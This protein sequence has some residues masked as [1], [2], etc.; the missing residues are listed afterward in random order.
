MNIN[1]PSQIRECTSCQ[2]CGAVCPTSAISIALNQDG[3]YRPVI[4]EVKCIDCS[5]C[6][7]S[8]YKFDQ[9]VRMTDSLESHT[10]L[11]A[12]VKDKEILNS[13]TSGGI[14]DILAKELTR[15][16]YLCIGVKYN[17]Q[18]N[19]AEGSIAS[20]EIETDGF[21][22]SKYIQSLS[23]DAFKTLAKENRK[24]KFAVFGLPCHIYALD[25]FLKSINNREPHILIDLFCH[26]CPSLLIWKKYLKDEVKINSDEEVTYV[27]FRSKERGW[28]EY[29]LKVELKS[30]DSHRTYISP[31]INDPFFGLFFSELVL[32]NSC[33]DCIVRRTLEYSEIRLGDFWGNKFL[34]NTTGVSAI[35]LSSQR[36]KEL[37]N[38]IDLHIN[39]EKQDWQSLLPYQSY[40]KVYH[41]DESLRSRLFDLLRDEEIPIKKVFGEYLH[42][43]PL[44][45]RIKYNLKNIFKLLPP[46]SIKTFKLI[47]RK[48]ANSK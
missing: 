36:A 23:I 26:G 17:T 1:D 28:G 34:N 30:E 9:D 31:K 18:Q 25:R 7:K 43:K 13:T 38:S 12:W 47:Y 37:I 10:L 42:A 44:A 16:G 41:I 3:F 19:I 45:F 15:Q 46:K 22:S 11:S 4:D 35:I 29:A 5:R 40:S 8:C 32:N 24:K 48:V 14:G 6:V 21:K 27:N 39:T 33:S 2:V 20:N